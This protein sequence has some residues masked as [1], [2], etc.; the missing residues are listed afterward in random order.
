MIWGKHI[1]ARTRERERERERQT[2]T[3]RQRD[4]DRQRQRQTDRQKQKMRETET[5]TETERDRETET[6]TEIGGVRSEEENGSD[7]GSLKPDWDR[8][9]T[10][11]PETEPYAVK[12]GLVPSEAGRTVLGGVCIDRQ[13]D[14]HDDKILSASNGMQIRLS[15]KCLRATN[16]GFGGEV[17]QVHVHKWL[18]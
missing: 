8:P 7:R 1:Q 9:A 15:G 18:G 10:K 11:A 4:R 5:E 2:E 17:L 13:D 12:P 3:E 14:G 6:E 16:C